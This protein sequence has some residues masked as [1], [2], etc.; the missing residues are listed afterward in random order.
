M[1]TVLPMWEYELNEFFAMSCPAWKIICPLD[2]KCFRYYLG[3]IYQDCF[4]VT[5]TQ[6]I[7]LSGALE[8]YELSYSK[9]TFSEGIPRRFEPGIGLPD[10]LTGV[11]RAPLA[12]V[13]RTVD[14]EPSS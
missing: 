14:P 6:V 3:T 9:G 5:E 12:H 1:L 4:S 7:R 13:W 11:P 2:L 8:A 10:I